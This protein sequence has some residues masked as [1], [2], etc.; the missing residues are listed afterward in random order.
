MSKLPD[1][2]FKGR[3]TIGRVYELLRQ[4]QTASAIDTVRVERD[5][6]PRSTYL[7]AVE[8]DVL[9][10]AGQT[11]A[12]QSLLD[13]LFA[14]DPGNKKALVIKA[15]MALK[16]GEAAGALSILQTHPDR[17]LPYVARRLTNIYFQLGQY[18]EALAQAQAMLRCAQTGKKDE[19]WF[20]E[21]AAR[22][23]EKLGE[24][25]QA[26]LLWQEAGTGVARV[27]VLRLKLQQLEP[28]Q[29]L[30]ELSQMARLERYDQ[31]AG[32][33]ALWAEQLAANGQPVEAADHWRRAALLKPGNPYYVKR[34]AYELKKAGRTEEALER[35][36]DAVSL[37]PNDRWPRESLYRLFAAGHRAEGIAFLEELIRRHPDAGWAYGHLKKLA[38]GEKETAH[39][40][41]T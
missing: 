22:S 38:E 7:M 6:N 37:D 41:N 29:A 34:W 12:A 8:A 35:F 1:R 30:R 17:T 3:E 4:G 40:P 11:T 18:R 36:K 25:D 10:R 21:M 16:K 2:S 31:D 23:L 28:D 5:N 39:G 14:L 20:K 33:Q 24:A 9:W 19:D 27:K 15:D 32:F 13:E 26:M